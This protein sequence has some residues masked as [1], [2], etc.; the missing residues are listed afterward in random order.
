M[1]KTKD[2]KETTL[3][4]SCIS[5]TEWDSNKNVENER[6][7]ESQRERPPEPQDD[8]EIEE[9]LKALARRKLRWG[10]IKMPPHLAD[11]LSSE[12]HVQHLGFGDE[13]DYISPPEDGMLYI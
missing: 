13:E 2:S 10:V 3:C 4:S 12:A 9:H 8:E 6:T 11:K 7:D 5:Y 1:V